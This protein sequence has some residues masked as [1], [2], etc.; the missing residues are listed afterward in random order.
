MFNKIVII[1]TFAVFVRAVFETVTNARK[2]KTKMDRF[3]IALRTP[4]NSW[5]LWLSFL[6][7]DVVGLL[8]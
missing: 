5:V 4:L 1:I 7:G 3:D 2:A 8:K 6:I